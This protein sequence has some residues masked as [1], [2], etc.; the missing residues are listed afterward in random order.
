MLKALLKK[1]FFEMLSVFSVGGKTK[2]KRSAWFTVAISL[3]LVYAIGMMVALFYIMAQ[4]VCA[5]LLS[6]NLSWVYFALMGTIAF[7]LSFMMCALTSKTTLFDAKDNELLLSMPI[8]SWNLLFVRTLGLYCMAF[9]FS[10]L[11][12][13]PTVVC[14]FVTAGFSWGVFLSCVLIAV[15]LPLGALTVACL[16]GFIM[17]LI[18]SQVV[19]KNLWT[20]IFL[21]AF[22]IVYSLLYSNANQI[23]TFIIANGA[24]VG[25]FFRNP[26]LL[27]F[28]Q[29]GLSATGQPLSTLLFFAI[30]LLTFAPVY[31]LMT[32][33]FL[34][35]VTKKRTGKKAKYVKKETKQSGVFFALLQ[36]EAKRYVKNPMILFNCGIGSVLTVILPIY[37]LIDPA[38]LPAILG[39]PIGKGELASILTVIFCFMVTSNFISSSSV[40][41]EGENLWILRSM[42][43]SAMQIFKVK[44]AFHFLFTAVPTVLSQAVLCALLKIPFGISALSIVTVVITTLLSA[45]LGFIVNLKF[46]NLKWTNEMVAVK[47]SASTLSAMLGGWGIAALVVGGYFLFGV[48]LYIEVFFLIVIVLFSL[49]TALM[50]LWLRTRGVEVFEQLS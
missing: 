3:L 34:Y 8:P 31:V 18:T 21:V 20:V 7:S 30:T 10:A 23:L 15:L 44:I 26:L 14:Y 27:F 32:K 22:L 45:I 19:N 47:Q 38:L 39:A 11:V 16:F 29:M 35:V 12:F 49:A 24:V 37:A 5:P 42:P 48:Y 50:A 41:L 36:K 17:A 6:Q 33:T 2:G 1:Q 9:F 25:E 40:S 13:I 28:Y 4:G 46:P 43:L